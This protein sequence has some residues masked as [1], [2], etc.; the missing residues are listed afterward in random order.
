MMTTTNGAVTFIDDS[1]QAASSMLADMV[2]M[3]NVGDSGDTTEMLPAKFSMLISGN[4]PADLMAIELA[5]A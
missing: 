3:E 5:A 4:T 1:N 2:A